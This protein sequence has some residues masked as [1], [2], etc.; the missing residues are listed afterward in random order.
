MKKLTS[1]VARTS[2]RERQ[3]YTM[4]RDPG[5]SLIRRAIHGPTD[6]R[7]GSRL[8][9]RPCGPLGGR[10]AAEQAENGRS[11]AGHRGMEGACLPQR[12]DDPG[13]FGMVSGDRILQVVSQI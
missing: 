10:A 4:G 1:G 5:K 3:V 12:A 7:A 8:S 11:A 2:R 13:D 9:E 6:E